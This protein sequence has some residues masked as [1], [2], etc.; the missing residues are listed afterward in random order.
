VLDLE[1]LADKWRSFG[2]TVLEIDGH[3]HG[4][5]TEVLHAD[6]TGRPKAILAHTVKG[7]GVAYMEGRLAWHYQSP[8]AKQLAEALAGLGCGE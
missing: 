6:S 3:D 1:P 5:I 2:W 4:A 8:D 7:K